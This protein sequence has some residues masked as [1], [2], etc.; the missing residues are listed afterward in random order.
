MKGKDYPKSLKCGVVSHL[1]GLP[2]H[3]S[4]ADNV[5]GLTLWNFLCWVKMM[6][7]WSPFR[8]NKICQSSGGRK[9][10]VS[11]Q[12][13]GLCSTLSALLLRRESFRRGKVTWSYPILP[14][15]LKTNEFMYCLQRDAFK[16]TKMLYS[17]KHW[18]KQHQRPA[19]IPS[20]VLGNSELF[21]SKQH[22]CSLVKYEAPHPL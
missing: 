18:V 15:I 21:L 16:N 13:H 11:C 14:Q 8:H 7:L 6:T 9:N 2:L 1:G 10:G 12:Q 17:K 5:P 19:F 3:C 20:A 4:M 22:V